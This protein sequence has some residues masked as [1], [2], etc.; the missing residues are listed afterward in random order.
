MYVKDEY[1]FGILKRA[2]EILK[3]NYKWNINDDDFKGFVNEDAY[4]IIDS[5]CDEII[6]LKDELEQ[7]EEEIREFYKPISLHE[8]YGVNESDFH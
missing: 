2:E 3:E 5:L 7:N 4:E 1:E 8:F 6:R